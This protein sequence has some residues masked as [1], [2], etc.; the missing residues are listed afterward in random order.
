MSDD[1]SSSYSTFHQRAEP[2]LRVALVAAFGADR[3]PEAALEALVYGWFTEL[4]RRKKH[5]G[6]E[7]STDS[8]LLHN[9]ALLDTDVSGGSLGVWRQQGIGLRC[10]QQLG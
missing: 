3:G 9:Q 7:G 5:S 1:D 6:E 2:R 4:A 8:S 10:R